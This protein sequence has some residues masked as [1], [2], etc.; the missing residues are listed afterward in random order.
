MEPNTKYALHDSEQMP[1]AWA[2][3]VRLTPELL[4][5]LRK[6][7]DQI[8]FK[9]NVAVGDGADLR[10]GINRRTSVLTVG[11]A[12]EGDLVET[13]EQYELLSFVEEPSINHACAFK[14]VDDLAGS[15]YNI[16]KTGAI[17]QKL[18]VQRLLDET[19][20]DRI[21]DKHA[22][23][24]LKSKSRTSRLISSEPMKAMNKQRL[25]KMMIAQTRTAELPE[26]DHNQ[27][28]KMVLTSALTKEQASE[29]EKQMDKVGGGHVPTNFC[30]DE[31]KTKT[32]IAEKNM[33]HEIFDNR[34]KN[35]SPFAATINISADTRDANSQAFF[36]S[37]SDGDV[38]GAATATKNTQIPVAARISEQC[39][40]SE[41]IV[42]RSGLSAK[43]LDFDPTAQ[44]N[45]AVCGTEVIALSDKYEAVSNPAM[46]ISR[47]RR[48]N[49]QH[50]LKSSSSGI[51]VKRARARS[52]LV[53]DRVKHACLPDMS[54]FPPA[55]VQICERLMRYHGRS[56]ILDEI[57]YDSIMETYEQFQQSWQLLDKAYSIEIVKTE[58]LH[59]QRELATF[60]QETRN[61]S[62]TCTQ[63]EGL[64]VIRDAMSSIKNILHSI[65]LSISR[66]DT[67]PT[68]P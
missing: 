19:E 67:K 32:C 59:L 50:P 46:P 35:I 4:H 14:R 58:G 30:T 42:K 38:T 8:R 37:E 64:L 53:S 16:Y 61:T 5:K 63:K 36:S 27:T 40:T 25:T 62:S 60:V 12:S 21:K 24:V 6:R 56:I 39:E 51:E 3:R 43:S 18:L 55:V 26:Y 52:T 22:K 45:E 29:A 20:K 66:F 1:T 41:L 34:E 9:L 65:Q 10:H 7:P 44:L 48:H 2:A 13:P 68:H 47:K 28:K 11:M 23:S 54:C 57:D 49:A 33:D 31:K 17:Y 15:G